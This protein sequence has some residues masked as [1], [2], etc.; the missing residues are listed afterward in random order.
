MKKHIANIITSCRIL[1]SIIM[2]FFPVFSVLFY[3]MYLLCGLTDMIDGTIAR[4]TNADSKFGAKLDTVADFIFLVV[5]LVKLLPELPIQRW[6]WIW[7]IVIAIIKISNIISGVILKKRF[8]VEHTIMNKITGLLFYLLPLT[9][10]L[11]E[12][13]YSAIVLCIIATFSAIQEGYFIRV[14]KEIV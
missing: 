7:T 14:G 4:K 5:A 10:N 11:I 6:L 1:C 9:L 13:K 12:L 2:V 8:I 3:I